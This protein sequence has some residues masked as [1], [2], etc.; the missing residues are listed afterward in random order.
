MESKLECDI[1]F[2]IDLTT[3]NDHKRIRL[4]KELLE[5]KER[6]QAR[7]G[8]IYLGHEKSQFDLIDDSHEK[9]YNL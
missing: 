1:A 5:E 9:T 3:K 7:F 2:I 8:I 4:L 6:K